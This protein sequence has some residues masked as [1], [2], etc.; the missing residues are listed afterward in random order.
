MASLRTLC[1]LFAGAHRLGSASTSQCADEEC[2]LV[3]ASS[4]LQRVSSVDKSMVAGRDEHAAAVTVPFHKLGR[5]GE[6]YDRF[7]EAP[8]ITN[9]MFSNEEENEC[10]EN[11]TEVTNAEE[12]QAAAEV[13][14]GGSNQ[15]DWSAV[16]NKS[17]APRG[18]YLFTMTS[19]LVIYNPHP[20]GAGAKNKY[21]ICKADFLF[22]ETETT[23][24]P[25]GSEPITNETA[26]RS[27][28]EAMLGNGFDWEGV[29]NE[30]HQPRGCYVFFMTSTLLY[31]NEHP[32]GRGKAYKNVLC[33]A[34]TSK[35]AVVNELDGMVRDAQNA[36]GALGEAIDALK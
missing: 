33:A 8:G 2:K 5:S 36:I 28:G 7:S 24:C 30:A 3:Q 29:Q 25:C 16:A 12:C 10:P 31:Y 9:Y 4:L 26:C 27:A 17:T 32:Q 22:G 1:L 19:D 20:T 15:V 13:L 34:K 6:P 18:C 14:R 35:E 23:T 11:S 21:K